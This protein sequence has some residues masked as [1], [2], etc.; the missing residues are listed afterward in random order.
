MGN[1]FR[2]VYDS[3]LFPWNCNGK[4]LMESVMSS[5]NSAS[6]RLKLLPFSLISVH[7]ISDQGLLYLDYQQCERSFVFK[8]LR[9]GSAPRFLT[10]GQ[11]YD[12]LLCS[13]HPKVIFMFTDGNDGRTTNVAYSCVLV[14]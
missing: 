14:T 8:F 13:T 11:L 9:S 10:H 4:E 6:T 3:I 12:E 5:A 2:P 7:A 1:I